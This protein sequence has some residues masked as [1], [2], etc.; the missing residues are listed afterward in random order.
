MAAATNEVDF[1]AASLIGSAGVGNNGE[2]L[3]ATLT[4]HY[5][6]A[7][8]A[9]L[10]KKENEKLRD[11]LDLAKVAK[12]AGLSEVEAATVRGG[13]RDEGD[14]WVT[15]VF[16]DQHGRPSKGAFPYGDLRGTS[17]D[18]LVTQRDAAGKSPEAEAHRVAQEKADAA[19]EA[20]AGPSDPFAAMSDASAGDLVKMMEEHPERVAAIKAFETATRGDRARKTVM[21]FEP[22]KDEG[23][24][25][26]GGAGGQGGSGAGSQGS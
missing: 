16:F 26:S 12:I 4:S 21:E 19:A 2:K 14:A 20:E 11:N 5:P 7:L 24:S 18:E 8:S 13:E 6:R 10:E 17:S 23:G 25:G 3:V 9:A 22:E 15:F 1:D